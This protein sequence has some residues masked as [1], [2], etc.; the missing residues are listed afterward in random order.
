MYLFSDLHDRHL[1]PAKRAP[2]FRYG[3]AFLSVALA[4]LLTLHAPAIRSGSPFLFFL[5]AVTMSAWYGG[6][7]AGLLAIGLA[8]LS[9]AFWV[10]SPSD[11][12]QITPWQFVQIGGFLAVTSSIIWLVS[13]LQQ[14]KNKVVAQREALRLTL[15]SI[16][17]AIIV[18]DPQATVRWMNEVAVT[19]T[20][21]R[22]T[23]AEGRPLAEVFPIVHEQTRTRVE[24]PVSRVLVEGRILGLA[25]HT[26]LLGKDGV[27]RPI[28]DSAA[29]IRDE[30]GQIHGVI[31]VFRDITERRHTEAAHQAAEE[32]FAKAFQASPQPM[33]I[34]DVQDGRYLD[35]NESFA[36][37]VDY[38]P[39]EIIGRTSFDVGI[40]TD[41]QAR[42]TV[43][44]TIV[45]QGS[46]R[47]F[48]HRFRTRNGEVRDIVSAGVSIDLAGEPYI[49]SVVNDV[50]AQKRVEERLR[51]LYQLSEAV[52]R[53]VALEQI[54][55]AAFAALERVL[56]VDRASILL[57]DETGVMRFKAWRSLSTAYRQQA[58]G[59]SPW[60]TREQNPILVLIPDVVQAEFGA[61]Q[62]TILEEGIRALA[63]IPLVE[64][65]QLLGKFM[66]YYNQP[67]P[68]AEAEVQ[69]AQTVAQHVARALQR[70]QAEAALRASEER[71]R[72]AQELSLDAFTILEAIRD[73]QGVIVDFVWRYAN[74]TAARLLKRSRAAL[75]GQRLLTVLPGNQA[76]SDLFDIYVQVVE[77]EQPQERELAYHAD[78]IEGWFRNI[79]VKLGDG[80]AIYFSDI[81]ARKQAEE[82][83]RY[84]AYLLDNLD[85]AVVA[86]DTNLR[87]TAWNSG[88]E[89]LYGWQAHEALGQPV[90]E[91]TGSSLVP[92]QRTQLFQMVDTTEHYH[93]EIMHHHRDGRPLQ[94]EANV[95][96][97]HDADN[98]R[99]GYVSINRDIAARKQAETALRASEAK[100]AKVFN[101]SPLVITITQ[102]AD[103]RLIEVNESF[104]QM[105]GYTREEVLGRTP[106][107][108]GLWVEP[109]QRAEGLVQLQASH[110]MR[111]GEVCFR[112][113]DGSERTCLISV[114]LLELN[115]QTCVLSVLNDITERKR[116]EEALRELN[117]TLDQQVQKRTE[118]LTKRLGELDQFAYVISHDL[119]APLR[120]I[121]HLAHWISDDAGDVLPLG[122]Q[123]HLATLRGRIKRME[124]LLDD[125]IAY[126]RADRYDYSTEQVETALLV[127]EITRLVAP[128]QGFAVTAQSPMPVLTT[129][130]VP[131]EMVLR[132]LIN[133][134]IKHHNRPNG[135]VQVL[136][137]D[138]GDYTEFTIT[139]DGPGIDPQFHARIFQVFQTLK[140]RDQIEGSGMGLAVVKKL[141]E[142]RGGSIQ[143][144]SSV[145]QGAAFRFT[146]PKAPTP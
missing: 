35:V 141:V 37:L 89:R 109:A 24:N 137:R 110:F 10:L 38:E 117:A 96:S 99:I 25:N 62:T 14:E 94:L 20:G 41:P 72:V 130:R 77:T 49:L 132:N 23:E 21:W 36:R 113:K 3:I 116:A 28:E 97:L 88:A 123:A 114:E 17:D 29:P 65:G 58:E 101:A 76:D 128:P 134:A 56:N 135:Q 142:S 11:S 122:S 98:Q 124:K 84:H 50:T 30:L 146:W 40:W 104:V 33:S 79:C 52:N 71:F 115:G 61:L 57:F 73:A 85:H 43:S 129:Q 63:F 120:A 119:K 5:L 54:Y 74:P 59:H 51:T 75:E 83:L 12:F 53:A 111:N 27:E 42:V 16:G 140:P 139:D 67:H 8:T 39:E 105:T 95:I 44:Q 107:E 80:V 18:T 103:G 7:R 112:M 22:V 91:V 70:Q 9:V 90:S 118:E 125:L 46:N 34:T 102:L 1:G 60:T 82:Q 108:V 138:L 68:F 6:P 45:Q 100:F 92:E 69:W 86:S 143:V 106:V 78:G 121:D 145:G 48:E 64:Q 136:A 26:V 47:N 87:V 55:D 81:T 127:E 131:L 93:L 31:L 126:S 15:A 133:N 13:T 19:L 144:E 2:F 32:R 66:L 4:L